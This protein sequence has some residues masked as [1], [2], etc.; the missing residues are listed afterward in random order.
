MEIKITSHGAAEEVTGSCHLLNIDGYRILI[1]CGMYQG[2]WENYSKNWDSFLFNPKDL[3]AVI[4]THAHLDHCGRLP[5]LMASGYNGP[6]FT[7]PPTIDLARIVLEDSYFIMDEKA[8]RKK[9]PKLYNQNDMN[10]TFKSF[11]PLNYYQTQQLTPDI[12][13]KFHNAG[14]ILGSAIVEI[15]AGSKTIVFSGDIGGQDMP[16]VKNIDI[17]HQ[18]DYVVCEGTYGDRTHHDRKTRDKE[19]I[20]AVQRATLNKSTLLIT[21]FA[22][23]RTQDI[24]KV[25]NDYYESHIDFNV[26]VFL[27]SPMASQATRVYK[28]YLD[29]LNEDSQTDLKRD[30]D[31]FNFPHLK[32][33]N[34]VR[35]S[36]EINKTPNPKIIMAG[37]GMMEGGRMIHHLAQYIDNKNNSILFMGFQVPGTLGY[38]IL[39][40]DFDFD[41]YGKKVPIKA[42]THQIDG[43]SAHA[44]KPALLKWLAGFK[45]PKKVFLVHGDKPILEKFAIIISEE[46]NTSAE[47]LKYNHSVSLK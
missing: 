28:K 9:M 23:E 37:S 36:K 30:K 12:S 47:V 6:I 21:I 41:Y 10:K 24:L 4:L 44:D 13:F 14:H 45:K 22:L 39:N 27:D 15:Q 26:P 31:I 2:D 1:D 18:A 5:K 46:L 43:F 16:L 11:V 34:H 19:L 17:I 32:I 8:F 3:D 25:L 35:Q 7:T 33:T 20:K 40:G 29:Y 42:A 38:K